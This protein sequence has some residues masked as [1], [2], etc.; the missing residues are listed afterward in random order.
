MMGKAS[1]AKAAEGDA[2]VFAAATKPFA[3]GKKR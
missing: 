2:P 3:G 1:E